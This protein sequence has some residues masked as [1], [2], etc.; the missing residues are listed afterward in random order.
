VEKHSVPLCEGA[1]AVS[2]PSSYD[3]HPMPSYHEPETATSPENSTSDTVRRMPM[4]PHHAPR[5]SGGCEV[6]LL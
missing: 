6:P 1:L 4:P 3:D 2:F 5:L